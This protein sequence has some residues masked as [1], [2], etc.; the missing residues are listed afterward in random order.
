MK[1]LHVCDL[2]V[3]FSKFV[4]LYTILSLVRFS[5]TAQKAG[6]IRQ[7]PENKTELAFSHC[8]DGV[9]GYTSLE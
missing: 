7:N 4:V 9:S 8:Q 3:A 6:P 5:R 2:G 1:V